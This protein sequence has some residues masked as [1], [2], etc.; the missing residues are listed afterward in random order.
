MSFIET[1]REGV[2]LVE[3]GSQYVNGEVIENYDVPELMNRVV[4]WFP[5]EVM[6]DPS[7]SNSQQHRLAV[8]FDNMTGLLKVIRKKLSDPEADHEKAWHLG[9]SLMTSIRNSVK[10]TLPDDSDSDSNFDSSNDGSNGDDDEVDL[11]SAFIAPVVDCTQRFLLPK[12]VTFPIMLVLGFIKTGAIVSAIDVSEEENGSDEGSN[13][14]PTNFAASVQN[15]FHAICTAI[16]SHIPQICNLLQGGT[17]N[18][19]GRRKVLELCERISRRNPELIPS[20]LDNIYPFIVTCIDSNTFHELLYTR[21]GLTEFWIDVSPK[22]VL[23]PL[24]RQGFR[25]LLTIAFKS[26]EYVVSNPSRMKE[27]SQ[28][29]SRYDTLIAEVSCNDVLFDA[30]YTLISDNDQYLIESLLSLTKLTELLKSNDTTKG[31]VMHRQ[32]PTISRVIDTWTPLFVFSKFLETT[33]FDTSILVDLLMSSETKFLEF[34]LLFVKN[35]TSQIVENE[36]RDDEDDDNKVPKK[37]RKTE[38]SKVLQVLEELVDKLGDLNA[39]GLFP[40]NPT[41][42]L[43]RIRILLDKIGMN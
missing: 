31:N 27:S 4:A 13:K 3:E 43:R 35:W 30:I 21:G 41:P 26:L 22:A 32:A 9:K 1:A 12:F 2:R 40:Y 34:L 24:D 37:R 18:S 19:Q 20:I 23:L 8:G 17:A 25:H 39:S 15:S 16:S 11:Y 28:L 14:D 5:V 38:S 42:L 33:G 36:F 29:L 7:L 6:L 10:R